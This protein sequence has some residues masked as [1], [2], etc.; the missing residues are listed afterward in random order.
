MSTVLL[1]D[2]SSVAH[3]IWHTSQG[4]TNPNE[5]SIQTVAKVRALAS[6]QPFCAI[7][8]DSGRSFRRELDP[9]YKANR[10]PSDATL[11]HQIALAVETLK[12]DGFPVWAVKGFEADDLIASAVDQGLKALIEVQPGNPGFIIASSDKDLLQLIGPRVVVKKITDGSEWD[13]GRV[14][15]N[16]GVNPNQIVDYLSIVG[17]ASDN[18]KGANGLG[19]KKAS[20]LLTKYGTLEDLYAALDKEGA[21]KEFQP[22]TFKALTEFRP[23]MEDVRALVRLRTDVPLPF[24]EVFTPRV[25][26]DAMTFDE[27]EPMETAADTVKGTAMPLPLE[28]MQSMSAQPEQQTATAVPLPPPSQPQSAPSGLAVREAEVLPPPSG[29]FTMQLEPRSLR[30]AALLAQEMFKSRLF[31]AYGTYQGVLSTILAGRELGMQAM[32]S[33]RAFHIIDGK[34]TMSADLIRALVIKSGHAEYFRCTERTAT[35]ATFI[36]KRKGDPE[37]SL[38]FTFAEAEKAGLVKKGSGWER[39]P[40]DMCVARASAKLCRLVYADVCFNMYAPEEFDGTN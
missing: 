37:V 25:P 33:L 18:I 32:A 9:T 1:V 30:E 19:A 26:V 10:P 3:P 6:G 13:E 23:R 20:A 11:Q 34:P 36:T 29:E 16:L 24:D 38:T 14:Y 27:G 5:C 40:V 22:S 21:E 31:S 8:C 15:V 28:V 17:D 35:Q 39:N 4:S 12:A 7:C 2:L